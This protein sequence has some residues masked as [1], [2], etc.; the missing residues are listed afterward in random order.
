[1]YKL[2]ETEM[3]GTHWQVHFDCVYRSITAVSSRESKLLAGNRTIAQV[4]ATFEKQILKSCLLHV[5]RQG[6]LKSCTKEID[7]SKLKLGCLLTRRQCHV[8]LAAL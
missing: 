7:Y 5:L 2:K 8:L 3:I 1:M 6:T 4:I